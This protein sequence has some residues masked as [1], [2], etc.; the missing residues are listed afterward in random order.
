MNKKEVLKQINSNPELANKALSN[1]YR[2]KT[3]A[4][5]DNNRVDTFKKTKRGA[6]GYIKKQQSISYYDDYTQSMV[7]CGSGLK[8]IE[9]KFTEIND[10]QTNVKMWYEYIKELYRNG[11]LLD[12][13]LYLAKRLEVSK[14]VMN[15]INDM[16]KEIKETRGYMVREELEET[17]Q[18][19][20]ITEAL[21]TDQQE[22]V[23]VQTEETNN[24]ITD[25]EKA[26][27]KEELNDPTYI[28]LINEYAE[29]LTTQ[30]TNNHKPA[31]QWTN[32]ESKDF[33]FFFSNFKQGVLDNEYPQLTKEIREK[34]KEIKEKERRLIE[35]EESYNKHDYE[36][37][38]NTYIERSERPKEIL[39]KEHEDI[40]KNA[41]EK[42]LNVPEEVLKD[43]KHL[44]NNE[45][46][47]QTET[48]ITATYKL[49]EEKNGIEIYF[50]EKPSQEVIGTLKAN[51]FRWS[52]YKK[53]WY[54]K[55]SDN[56]IQLAKQLT[57]SQQDET[58]SETFEYPEIEIDDIHEYTIDKDL[59][60][61]EHS[62]NWIF[63]TKETDHTKKIQ[64]LFSYYTNEVKEILKTID[65]EYYQYKI[66]KALQSFK[67]KYH[68][69]YVKWLS[70]KANCPSWAV[71]GRGNLNV[72]SY[73]KKQERANNTMLELASLPEEFEK[74]VKHYK[75]KALKEKEQAERQEALSA[76]INI[77]FKTETKEFEYMKMKE[78]KR[79]YI[80]GDYW[81]CKLWGAYRIFKGNKEIYECKS[82]DKL[83]DVKKICC[84]LIQ[85]DQ[86]KHQKTA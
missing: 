61:R 4:I 17:E 57:N 48:N 73:N 26:F 22:E 86:Q 10:P 14:E 28:N 81:F 79:V 50:T 19:E 44:I 21:I 52:K 74:K 20:E 64:D 72:R 35:I 6:Q 31:S 2:D 34:Y 49:N 77:T 69:L 12:E 60:K 67:K 53:C 68:E 56:T 65:N 82:Y 55:Q 78:K 29:K 37:P 43:Y 84:Y 24:N 32:K 15:L 75:Y 18:A 36:V 63:R 59:Q 71:T 33:Q 58:P 25:Q 16:V 54:A 51:K 7:T 11:W 39:I 13:A 38:L 62:A 8:I 5:I 66:K 70:Q 23:K 80:H 3:F 45:K 40:V 9:I 41:I 46:H 47:E 30:K 76:N 1:I 85:K 42:G 27:T 83:E